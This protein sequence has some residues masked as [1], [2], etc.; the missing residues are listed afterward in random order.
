MTREGVEARRLFYEATRSFN[1]AEFADAVAKYREGLDIWEKL[2]ANYPLYAA[3]DQNAH[4]TGLV[5]KRDLKAIVNAGLD[6]PKTV[7][8]EKLAKLVEFEEN[9]DPFD[10]MEMAPSTTTRPPRCSRGTPGSTRTPKRGSPGWPGQSEAAASGAPVG[11][12]RPGTLAALALP[13]PPV[14]RFP[15]MR[16]ADGTRSVPATFL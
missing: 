6:R 15:S 9:P 3:D 14:V 1:H 10:E 11:S 5:V 12:T 2:L 13:R 7:P 4:D 8:F 16:R